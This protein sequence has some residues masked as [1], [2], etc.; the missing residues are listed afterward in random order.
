MKRQVKECT[1]MYRKFW[2]HYRMLRFVL[3]LVATLGT[4][5][6]FSYWI[7]GAHW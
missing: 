3:E 6:L 7:L 5:A 2:L 1:V 4:A